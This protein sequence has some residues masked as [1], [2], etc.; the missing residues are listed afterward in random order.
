MQNINQLKVDYLNS[1]GLKVEEFSDSN[2][3]FDSGDY[4]CDIDF[5]E[6]EIG[7]TS[8][9]ICN[10]ANIYSCCGD[11]LDK[12]HMMCPTCYEHC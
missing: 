1:I 6:F 7:D 2:V 5:D 9:S 8:Q 4:F 12:D 11:I 10:S 3:A